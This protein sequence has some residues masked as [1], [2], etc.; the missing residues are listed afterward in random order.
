MIFSIYAK[1]NK[2]CSFPLGL[3][4]YMINFHHLGLF[5][6]D[7][8]T[9]DINKKSDEEKSATAEKKFKKVNFLLNREEEV[10]FFSAVAEPTK[11]FEEVNFLKW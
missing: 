3:W 7:S 11:M 6:A 2:S 5:N 4:S 10:N 1:A 8:E 9:V